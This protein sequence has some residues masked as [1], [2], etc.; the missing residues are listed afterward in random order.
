M[1]LNVGTMSVQMHRENINETQMLNTVSFRDLSND[2]KIN[3]LYC[4]ESFPVLN[5]IVYD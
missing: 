4:H 1:S 5:E 2:E 3:L